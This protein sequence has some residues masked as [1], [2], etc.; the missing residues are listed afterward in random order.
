MIDTGKFRVLSDYGDDEDIPAPAPKPESL[1][2]RLATMSELDYQKA[3]AALATAE[4]IGVVALDTIRK[5]AKKDRAKAPPTYDLSS[6][7]PDQVDGAD[8]AAG[9]E[10]TLRRFVVMDA[11]S[12]VLITLWII[13]THAYDARSIWPMLLARSPQPGCGK[14]TLL[15]V[16]ERIVLNAMAV[17]NA[18]LATLFRSA[19]TG[20][21]QL[22]DELDRWIERDPEVAG[23]LCAGWQ[24][25]RPFT[26]CHP[27]TFEL[28]EFPCYCPKALALIGD[29]R[30]EAVR[31]RCIIVEMR[32]ALPGERPERFRSG[33]GYPE[34]VAL[35]AK[36]ARWTK[37]NRD[38]IRAFELPDGDLAELNGR[39][40]DNAEALLSI[41]ESIG[42]EWVQ[43]CRDALLTSRVEE[44]QDMG[45][46]LLADLR[47]LLAETPDAEAIA[48]DRILDHLHRL[49][50]RPWPTAS[51]GKPITPH[52]FRRRMQPF[53]VKPGRHYVNG[54][55][56]RGY[57][58]APIWESIKR[59]LPPLSDPSEQAS[60][61]AQVSHDEF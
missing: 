30:D 40:A 37:D 38:S 43:R 4:G 56:V 60:Q 51:K 44:P 26:R 46:M 23:Y 6:L 42:S 20:P 22:L 45:A 1:T 61:V 59:Y 49:D 41:A 47:D 15:D 32:R 3:R 29:V 36:A 31:S 11:V 52:W 17:G 16:L 39:A 14:T 28:V 21:T 35:R 9:I 8:L 33:K 50:D 5:E 13:G 19:A 25:G 7:W 18:S 57:L 10:A 55:R 53:G 24:S 34:L 54:M 27:E 58:A 48:T 2:D 12:Y